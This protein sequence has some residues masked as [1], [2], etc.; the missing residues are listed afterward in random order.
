GNGQIDYPNGTSFATPILAGLSACLWQ[1]LPELT[2]FEIIELLRE[3]ANAF[4]QP[5][6]LMGFGIADVYKAYTQNKTGLKPAGMENAVY[7][8]INARENRLYLNFDHLQNNSPFVLDIYSGVGIKLLSASNVSS[9][10]DI[11][12]LQKGIYIVRLQTGGKPVFVRKFIK[13]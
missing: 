4:S 3:T 9:S 7:F 12:L 2:C 11:S 10:I 1:A 13:M 5:D 8:H 6:S